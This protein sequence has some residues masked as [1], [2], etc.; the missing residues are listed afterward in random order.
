[1]WRVVRSE[2]PV[3]RL[4]RVGEMARRIRGLRT[5]WKESREVRAQAVPFPDRSW[6]MEQH[7]A[8]LFFLPN[9]TIR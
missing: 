2:A 9:P 5:E 3:G 1:M 8:S 7:T 4:R 6:F